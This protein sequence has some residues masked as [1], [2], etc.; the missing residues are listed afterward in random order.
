VA[1]RFGFNRAIVNIQALR[2]KGGGWKPLTSGSANSS[3]RVIRARTS[4][5]H[6]I[7][8][9]A[10]ASSR[11]M[12]GHS[13]GPLRAQLSLKSARGPCRR[14]AQFGPGAWPEPTASRQPFAVRW[15]PIIGSDESPCCANRGVRW[16]PPSALWLLYQI[17][18][19]CIASMIP[20]GRSWE[21]SGTATVGFHA[22]RCRSF[23][24]SPAQ[25]KSGPFYPA[26]SVR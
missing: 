15:G 8:L 26:K 24:T 12:S 14:L 11:S 18:R 21:S 4:G 6:S 13:E 23:Y 2:K 25:V 22:Q 19:A 20:Q 5:R 17:R 9:P 1:R 7:C 16:S 3:C 10:P